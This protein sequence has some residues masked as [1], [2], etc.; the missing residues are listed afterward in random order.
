MTQTRIG[1][2][3]L[4][5]YVPERIMTNDEWAQLIDTSDEWITTRTG[6]K[7]RRLAADNENTADL[8]TF[9]AER[10]LAD[11]GLIPDQIDEIIVAS[12]TP[13]VY[14]PDTASFVQH[15]LG[16]S[17]IPT[18]DLAGSGCAGFV[19]GLDIARSRVGVGDRRVLVIGVEL[20]TRLMSWRDRNTCVLFGDA[21]G[22]AVVGAGA[23]A[24]EIV[25]ATAGTDG[26]RG[27]ILTAEVGGTRAPFNVERARQLLHQWIVMKGREV[28][29]E[30]T[31]R[32]SAA[33]KEVLTQ[34]G[35][36][37]D[38]VALVIPHQAN[39]RIIQATG[40]ALGVPAEKVY[41][42]VQEYGNTGSASVPLALWEARQQ[43]RIAV[44]DLVLLTSFGAGFHWAAMLLRF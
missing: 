18:Y 34:A 14:T 23:G 9:A 11:A 38:D 3:G 22:A 30:A 40:K 26:S 25:A 44:G 2:I 21:A 17:E 43:G 20:L 29:K 27:H 10:A 39:L 12:D 42:N 5:A 28:F 6:I 7:R 1:L 36:D 41:V 4:G 8:A 15:R 37:V 16:A 13:E 35:L 31:T 33:A 19:L 24:A 32:M